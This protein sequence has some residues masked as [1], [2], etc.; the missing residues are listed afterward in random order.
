M[1]IM[2]IESSEAFHKILMKKS[3][4]FL[5]KNSITCPISR[6]G[7]NEVVEFAEE[8]NEVPVLYLN[9]QESRDVS[10]E[11]AETYSVKHESPQVLL[12]NGDQVVWHASHWKVT[13][14]NLKNAWFGK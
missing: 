11:I 7:Y 8:N 13:K 5:L 9:V 6:E 3:K 12:F 4:L 10:N 1:N 14:N 2:K